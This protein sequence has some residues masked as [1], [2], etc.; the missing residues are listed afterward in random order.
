MYRKKEK[1]GVLLV[2]MYVDDLLVTGSLP[3]LI[4]EFKEEMARKFEMTDLGRLT[5]YLGIEV[6]QTGGGIALSQERYAQKI[7]EE[8]GMR[9]CNHV[10]IPMDVN[11][12]LGKS[13]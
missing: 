11:V 8:F 12:K 7:L 5:Y 10:H 3:N 13:S 2:C 1:N 6:C 9:D 4:T